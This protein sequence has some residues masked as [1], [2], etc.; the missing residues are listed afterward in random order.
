MSRN[1]DAFLRK[2]NKNEKAHYITQ[3]AEIWQQ[4]HL[5]IIILSRIELWAT[6]G[7][8]VFL[9][10]SQY[11]VPFAVCFKSFA[12][13]WR[14][15]MWQLARTL[16]SC[17]ECVTETR[18]QSMIHTSCSPPQIYEVCVY[19]C[20]HSFFQLL[21]SFMFHKTFRSCLVVSLLYPV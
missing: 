15:N 8:D 20:H 7:H 2:R 12:L 9:V 18:P 16:Q 6:S 17:L 19:C 5:N 14:R 1:S 13:C 21:K 10:V 11:R 3:L 4:W